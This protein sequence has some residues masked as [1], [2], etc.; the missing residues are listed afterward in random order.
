MLRMQDSRMC[1]FNASTLG[2]EDEFMLM[3][4]QSTMQC[5]WTVD[6][7]GEAD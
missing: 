2:A 6:V 7:S 4:L 1:W 5:C 3:G